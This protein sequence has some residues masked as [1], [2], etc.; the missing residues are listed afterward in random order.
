MEK[1]TTT[2]SFFFVCVFNIKLIYICRV[3]VYLINLANRKKQRKMKLNEVI[4]DW[5][6]IFQ[7]EA[8]NLEKYYEISIF[9]LYLVLFLL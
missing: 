5:K 6:G 9:E 4:E 7:S 2:L 1:F 8:S 3:S